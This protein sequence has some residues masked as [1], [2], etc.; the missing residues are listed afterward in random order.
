MTDRMTFET[1]LALSY[2]TWDDDTKARRI[3]LMPVLEGG[4]VRRVVDL[5][6]YTAVNPLDGPRV[7]LEF[8]RAK[9]DHDASIHGLSDEVRTTYD[10]WLARLDFGLTAMRPTTTSVR[11]DRAEVAPAEPE[12]TSD[13]RSQYRAESTFERWRWRPDQEPVTIRNVAQTLTV[14]KARAGLVLRTTTTTVLDWAGWDELVAMVE[15]F[16]P[17]AAET[18]SVG[19]VPTEPG[20]Y[21]MQL[22]GVGR[23]RNVAVLD[24]ESKTHPGE[25]RWFA[26]GIDQ[27][28]TPAEFRDRVGHATFI[29]LAVDSDPLSPEARLIEDVMAKLKERNTSDILFSSG[30]TTVRA[31]GRNLTITDRVDG[32]HVTIQYADVAGVAAS[33]RPWRVGS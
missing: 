12:P 33:M 15:E 4:K 8:S 1:W 26:T 18:T 31:D 10:K 28:W 27:S 24:D 17:E 32:D 19:D 16:R 21:W 11:V 2:P 6:T 3:C 22:P 14:D 13:A 25:P 30:R 29:R 5:A 20:F 7:A 23:V 9:V